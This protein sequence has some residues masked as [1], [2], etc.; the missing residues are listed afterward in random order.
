MFH[1][2]DTSLFG[3]GIDVDLQLAL[4]GLL[5]KILD[6]V[7]QA[8]L[9]HTASVYLTAWMAYY[10]GKSGRAG[11]AGVNLI[12]FGLKDELVEPWTCMVNFW[13]RCH[14]LGR[15][16][17]GWPGFLR[18]IASL[19][20]SVYVLLLALAINT[21][22]I[23][24]ER[25]YPN[26]AGR[27][28]DLTISTPRMVLNGLDWMNYW[29]FGF[30]LVGSGDQSWA[31]A[32]GLVAASTFTLLQGLPT[33]YRTE[34]VGWIPLSSEKPGFITAI[35]TLI[36]GS[37]VQSISVQNSRVRDVFNYLQ[38]N[39]TK[40][41][42]KVASGWNGFVNITAP[43]LT[44][45]CVTGLP[46]NLSVPIGTIPVSS[47]VQTM[48]LADCTYQVQGPSNL[49][50][51]ESTITIPIGAIP[52][53][54]FT[55]ATCSTTLRQAL[56]PVGTWIVNMAGIDVS[57]NNYGFS[58]NTKPVLLDPSSG[59]KASAQA[60]GIQ[61]G[62]VVGSMNRLI[63]AGLV[64]EMV[65]MSRRLSIVYPGISLTNDTAGMAAIVAAMAQHIL[66][67]GSWNMTASP[68][69]SQLTTSYPVR[70]QV[71]GAGPRLAWEWATA[72]VIV[73]IL[74]ALLGGAVLKAKWR[75]R[76]GPWLEVG[77]MMLAAND[78]E[79]ME[80]VKGSCAGEASKMAKEGTYFMR[81]VGKGVVKLT[82]KASDGSGLKGEVTYE[83]QD[84]RME[85]NRSVDWG[86][87]WGF[88]R[89][90]EFMKGVLDTV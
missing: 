9:K 48:F 89:V 78:S 22:G 14:H 47:H 70:W 69:H 51:T 58:M 6:T 40:E 54:N 28:E 56:F 67:I 50:L 76:P 3:L 10:F 71:Y 81:D 20:V 83:S 59:D 24:K 1:F 84:P 33:A 38:L 21:L 32:I 8:S 27:E 55:G 41:Y 2:T 64:Y 82:D 17:I 72:I 12:D 77:G 86:I 88:L 44:T 23:P 73:V 63:P 15:R 4:I 60:L 18:F 5:N 68:E 37:T 52:L 16:K 45:T 85:Y 46:A 34:P 49:S 42:Y 31:V 11:G 90:R 61:I 80:S 75:I 87:L 66:S 74:V 62:S 30:D 26:P 35:N 65:L 53:L 43:M 25:W 29:G 79:P 57:I 19:A 39:G 13:K 36:N 7:V